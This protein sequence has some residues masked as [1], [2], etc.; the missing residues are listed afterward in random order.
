VRPPNAN[1]TRGKVGVDFLVDAN[2]LSAEDDSG[3][4][5]LN[6][7]FYVTIFSPQGK[8]L[9]Q[10]SQK[11]D[12]AF[13]LEVYKQIVEKGMLLHMDIDPQ[14]GSGQVRLA[15]QDNRTGL[16]GTIDAPLAQ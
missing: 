12:R 3:G 4:K 11:V 2:T 9:A 13:P 15:V 10:R 8:M 14:P 5:K 16:V 7:A 1:S 6:V